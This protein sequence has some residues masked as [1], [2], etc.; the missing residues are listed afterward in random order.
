MQRERERDAE[1]ERERRMERAEGFESA[2]Q[3]A[4][5]VLDHAC[6][7]HTHMNIKPVF[8]PTISC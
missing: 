2:A 8:R 7:L 4:H 1:R 3:I 6:S 5:K